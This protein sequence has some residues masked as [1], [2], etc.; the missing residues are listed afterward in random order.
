MLTG[1]M[2]CTKIFTKEPQ[3]LLHPEYMR[4]VY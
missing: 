3:D 1:S 2:G 4:C